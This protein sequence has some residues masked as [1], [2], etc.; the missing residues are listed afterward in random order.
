MP[1]ENDIT[2]IN[3][4]D[5]PPG[6]RNSRILMQPHLLLLCIVP[7]MPSVDPAFEDERLKN[8][9]GY[10]ANSPDEMEKELHYYAKE[11]LEKGDINSA[12]QVLLTIENV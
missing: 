11:L 4:G 7:E 12:W 1:H 6:I 2:G 3:P 8:I 5:L 9:I 10:F